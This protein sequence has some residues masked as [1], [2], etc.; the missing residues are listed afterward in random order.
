MATSV[1]RLTHA[2]RP[3]RHFED[4]ELLST[5]LFHTPNNNG[6]LTSVL[7]EHGLE[8]A[9]PEYNSAMKKS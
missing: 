5:S 8:Q 3:Q 6:T 7:G 9:M 1:Q 2:P 4:S